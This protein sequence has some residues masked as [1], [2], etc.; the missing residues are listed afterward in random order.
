MTRVPRR[1]GVLLGT[2]SNKCPTLTSPFGPPHSPP[3]PSS[4]IHSVPLPHHRVRFLLS[5][6][7]SLPLHVHNRSTLPLSSSPNTSSPSAARAVSAASSQRHQNATTITNTAAPVRARL[8]RA[9]AFHPT[10]PPRR[11]R[12]CCEHCVA[13][14]S[15]N[16]TTTMANKLPQRPARRLRV[17]DRDPADVAR[18]VSAAWCRPPTWR[19]R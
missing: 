14:A 13:S 18:A 19:L 9:S 5:F 1:R 8:S 12:A 6:P 15:V 11:R 16:A 7:L 3:F 10:L 17:A 2:P 4:S